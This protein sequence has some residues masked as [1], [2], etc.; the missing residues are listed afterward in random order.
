MTTLETRHQ[1]A[2][3]GTGNISTAFDPG[4]FEPFGASSYP[5]LKRIG[6]L[7]EEPWCTIQSLKPQD[8]IPINPYSRSTY[9]NGTA[10]W[11]AVIGIPASTVRPRAMVDGNNAVP[12]RSINDMWLGPMFQGMNHIGPLGPNGELVRPQ[13]PFIINLLYEPLGWK[14][15]EGAHILVHRREHRMS[16]RARESHLP[17]TAKV[18][19]RMVAE[20]VVCWQYGLPLDVS[21]RTDEPVGSPAIRHYGLDV[22]TSD[23]PRQPILRVP[24]SGPHAPIPDVTMGCIGTGVFIEPVPQ[25][26]ILEH[27]NWMECNRWTCLPTMVNITGWEMMDVIS[28]YP[29]SAGSPWNPEKPKCYTVNPADLMS[30]ALLPDL[31][32]AA[33]EV[34]GKPVIDQKRYWL[35]EDWLDGL[36]Y[37]KGIMQT[38]PFPC[39]SCLGY[40]TRTDGAPERPKRLWSDPADDNA[41]TKRER[42]EWEAVRERIMRIA[43]KATVFIESGLYGGRAA[44]LAM[45][46]TRTR[47]HNAENRYRDKVSRLKRTIDKCRLDG[48]PSRAI[49]IQKELDT[50][51]KTHNERATC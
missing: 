35:V 28:H 12:I 39:E 25:G 45:R 47:A 50:L 30:P 10:L 46:T 1:L 22:R 6:R 7:T 48:L 40:N 16:K 51:I 13:G 9:R 21:E 8:I 24:W 38:P 15:L 44:T 29:L 49:E 14:I 33:H 11:D 32:S 5:Y 34:I 4:C 19:Q 23:R 3:S 20:I 41:R 2:V 42:A 18:L 27:E 36:D 17:V 43:T 37:R 26:A 31:L